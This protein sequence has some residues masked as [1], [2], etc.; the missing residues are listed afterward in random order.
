MARLNYIGKRRIEPNTTTSVGI[1][2]GDVESKCIKFDFPN[3]QGQIR[4]VID[5]READNLIKDLKNII[6]KLNSEGKF[7]SSQP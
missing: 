3:S 5:K 1:I 6:K 7:F 2:F 4:I